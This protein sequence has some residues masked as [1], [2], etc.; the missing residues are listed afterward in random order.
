MFGSPETTSGG[1]ALKF[2]SSVRM[3]IRRVETL[4]TGTDSV[5]NKVKVKIVKNKLAPPFRQ[6][7]FDIMFG[8]GIS[9]EGSIIDMGVEVGI[10]RK[11]GSWFTYDGDQLGQGKENARNYLKEHPEVAEEIADKINREMKIG[12]YADALAP[13]EDELA[14]V[15]DNGELELD[16][17]DDLDLEDL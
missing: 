12:K 14:D 8:E 7:E 3:D 17:L 5:G 4:K 15:T 16:D 11:S 1:R 13:D 2:Y 6:V 9:K 10:V